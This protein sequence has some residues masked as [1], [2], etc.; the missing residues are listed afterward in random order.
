MDC[1]KGINEVIKDLHDEDAADGEV[2]A[3]LDVR[4]DVLAEVHHSQCARLLTEKNVL[5]RLRRTSHRGHFIHW[6]ACSAKRE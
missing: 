1:S 5:T 2:V 6:G 4:A 3:G